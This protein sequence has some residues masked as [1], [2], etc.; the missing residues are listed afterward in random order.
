[1]SNRN[2]PYGYGPSEPDWVSRTSPFLPCM[3]CDRV[4]NDETLCEEGYCEDCSPYCENCDERSHDYEIWKGRIICEC[5]WESI[6]TCELCQ[7]ESLNVNYNDDCELVCSK[8]N[9]IDKEESNE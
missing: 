2:A 5:C 7:V 6:E 8:C 9:I 3:G 4:V 1:M